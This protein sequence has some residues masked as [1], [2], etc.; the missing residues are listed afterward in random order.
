MTQPILTAKRRYKDREI[1]CKFFAGPS[2]ETIVNEVF[3][4]NYTIFEKELEFAPGDIILDLGANEGV[5]SIMMAKMFPGVKIIA[6]EPVPRT[7]YQL[8]QNL[9]L[10]ELKL[11][12]DVAAFNI[13]V[14]AED[15][16]DKTLIVSRDHSG[17][18][19][20]WCTFNP[21]HHINTRVIIKSLDSILKDLPQ[22]KLLKIDIEGME[23]ETLYH[24]TMLDKVE[25][26]V[27]EFHSNNRL[28]AVSPQY[29]P[30]ELATYLG[31][32]GKLVYFERIP[33]AE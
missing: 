6:Y 2:T 10:N 18:S 16:T 1:E 19:T 9:G 12:D 26:I 29:D 33:M 27:G 20:A 5:F 21:A 24:C 15:S 32:M 3:G 30:N 8:Y 13:G 11:M 7:F 25:M 23:Y 22:V 31:D 28:R 4:D 14:G 17:G